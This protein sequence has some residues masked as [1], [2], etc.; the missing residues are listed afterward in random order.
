MAQ[1]ERTNVS[2]LT[3]ESNNEQTTSTCLSLRPITVE[4]M[5]QPSVPSQDSF[6]LSPAA[7]QGRPSHC[8]FSPPQGSDSGWGPVTDCVALH[9]NQQ[10]PQ[11]QEAPR[12]ILLSQRHT[13]SWHGR[14]HTERI[15]A[16]GWLLDVQGPPTA[17]PRSTCLFTCLFSRL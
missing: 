10:E 3:S 5:A 12:F 6:T 7:R 4:T 14:L 9:L 1:M 16:G 8:L 11:S 15:V 2:G 13:A 17:A